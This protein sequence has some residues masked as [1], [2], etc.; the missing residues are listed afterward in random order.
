MLAV[1]EVSRADNRHD[2]ADHD[3][4]RPAGDDVLGERRV[5]RVVDVVV[6]VTAE[7]R[8]GLRDEAARRREVLGRNAGRGAHE[9]PGSESRES[10]C[11]VT[12]ND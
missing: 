11:A 4:R 3:E 2:A 10:H 9:R 8:L 1:L 5:E 12:A 6:V 7:A